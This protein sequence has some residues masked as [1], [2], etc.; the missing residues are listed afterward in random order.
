[1]V[2]TIHT[3]CN[4]GQNTNVDFTYSLGQQVMMWSRRW[5]YEQ[6]I[7]VAVL[8]KFGHYSVAYLDRIMAFEAL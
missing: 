1:M 6:A 7:F 4:Y 2:Q 8:G 5:L 3:I